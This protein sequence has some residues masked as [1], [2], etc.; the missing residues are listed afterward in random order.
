[1]VIKYVGWTASNSDYVC[2]GSNDQVPINEALA[3]AAANPGNTIYLRGPY[4]YDIYQTNVKIGSYTEL[5]GDSTAVLRLNNS[6]MWTAMVPVIGQI[7]GTG[8]VTKSV[9]IHGFQIDCNESHL[10]HAGVGSPERIRG[11][12]YYNAIYIVGQ[13]AKPAE[14]IQVYDM[15]I[16]DSMGDGPRIGFAT[17]IKIHDCTMWNMQHCAVFCIDSD[18]IDIYNNDLQ[19]ITCSAV[20]LDNCR[21]WKVHDNEIKDWL[22]TSSAPVGGAHGVQ[23]GNQPAGYGHTRQTDNGEVYNNTINVGACGIQIEDYYKSSGTTARTVHIH[24]NK[25]SG[26]GWQ[27]TWAAYFSGIAIFSWGNG[28]TIEKNTIENCY[29]AGILGYG[30]IASGVKA[31]I[32]NNNI[33]GTVAAGSTGGYGIWDKVS[34]ALTIVADNNYLSSNVSKYSGVTPVSESSSLIE[35]AVPTNTTDD[36]EEDDPTNEDVPVDIPSSRF[37]QKDLDKNYYI[38]G[39]TGYINGK[40]FRWKEKSVDVA[41]SVGQ[42][43]CPGVVGWSITDFDLNG[44][45]LTLD[46]FSMSGIREVHEAIAAFTQ[47]GRVT[48]E[49]GGDYAE[50]QV[51]GTKGDYSSKVRLNSDI[52]KKYHPYSLLLL[53][54][55]PYF[56]SVI[57]RYR[58]RY[59]TKSQSFSAD[60]CFKGNLVQNSSFDEWTPVNSMTWTT[61]ASARDNEWRCI[62]YAP[63]LKQFCAV[64]RTGTNTRVMISD[65]ETWR[66]PTGLTNANRNNYW[67][68][69]L[70][71]AEWGMW[72]ATSITGT[73][74]RCMIS[75]DGDNWSKKITPLDNAWVALLWI[76]PDSEPIGM[77]VAGDL[78]FAGAYGEL[79]Y[80]PE[81]GKHKA[82]YTGRVLAFANTGNYRVMYSD[83]KCE[84]W[85]AIPSAVETNSWSSAAYSPELHRI[86]VVASS[87]ETGQQVMTSDDFGDTWTARTTPTPNQSWNSVVWADALSLFVAVSSDGTKQIMT[88]PN[89]AT[90]TL[91]DTPI[92]SSTVTAGSG[93]I[94]S[95]T[96]VSPDGHAYPSSAI[97]YEEVYTTSVP[98]LTNGNFYRID[99]VAARLKTAVAG[100][101][102][103]MK[104]TAETASLGEVTLATWSNN[105]TSYVQ[106]LKDVAVLTATN[107]ALTIHYYLETSV[108]TARAHST[109]LQCK[110]TETNGGGSVVDYTNE[111]TSLVWSPS[112]KVLVA[113]AQTGELN[114][115]MHSVDALNWI[116]DTTPNNNAWVSV[117]YAE[118]FNRF[119]A[120][121]ITGTGNRVMIS[122]DYGS[123]RVPDSWVSVSEGQSR[124]ESTMEDG[125]ALRIT[126][127][128]TTVDRGVTTQP[129][130]LSAGVRYLLSGYGKVEGLTS[131]SLIIDVYSGD[132]AIKGLEWVSDT[133]YLQKQHSFMFNVAP[134]NVSVRVR[135]NNLNGGAIVECDHV[136]VEKASDLEM[137]FVGTDVATYG[138]VD[139]YPDIILTGVTHAPDF[140]IPGETKSE[141]TPEDVEY[142]SSSTQYSSETNSLVYTFR[143]PALENEAYYR[144]DQVS[145][146]LKTAYAGRIAYARATIQT[147]G[148][149]S[150]SETTLV[151]WTHNTTT[152]A[153]KSKSLNVESLAGDDIYI[154]F[155]LKTSNPTYRAS[156]ISFKYVATEI[157]TEAGGLSTKDVKIHNAADPA[158]VM[159]CCDTLLPKYSLEI[160][161]NGTGNLSYSE[162]FEDDNY[163]DTA[164]ASSGVTY[165][166]TNK[167]IVIGSGGYITFQ[168]PCKFPVTGIPYINLYALAGSPQIYIAEDVSG[169]PG[170]FYEV[171]GNL[172]ADVENEVVAKYLNCTSL[173]LKTK[174][175]YYVKITPRGSGTCEFGSLYEYAALSTVDAERFKL[176]A[177]I[178]ANTIAVSVDGKASCIATLKYHDLDPAV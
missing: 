137:L 21:K 67:W 121:S 168:F 154:R 142:V 36:E 4:T 51:T 52:P 25:I 39:R 100:K 114:G 62:Q 175:K 109:G 123:F 26:C 84:T 43:K 65:G 45:E 124:A 94:S 50:W 10:T 57:E 149:Y 116:S 92:K 115:C 74:D 136:L 30:A 128:G 129:L 167:S 72:I 98:A 11:K 99:K 118:D 90:W 63:E 153:E 93:D 85:K 108:A 144:L 19:P 95:V 87:G 125:Y 172:S 89:G 59:I 23:F 155:Y 32:K 68:A 55:Q 41:N 151:E 18:E 163:L 133:G 112:L 159:E 156:A 119:A 69:L 73:E 33:T 176:L 150:G 53:M 147:D 126:G 60:N 76:P 44:A 75:L 132:T 174:V 152:Y 56:E 46:C 9:K 104:V 2:D 101:V 79:F 34:S 48:I 77:K 113:V 82:Q 139:V 158:T 37:Y 138:T 38:E 91:V 40:P 97:S 47:P 28:L 102:A 1:M 24:H 42:D 140:A 145:C 16:H 131:G 7:G 117:C 164:Y 130:S 6:C 80:M 13:L 148:R 15:E 134:S 66:Y 49:L 177:G 105:T 22:G 173:Q 29:R 165:N 143:L 170:T 88:S 54:D 135:G 27:Y 64:S 31:T 107:E 86:V 169:T 14:D 127:D 162:D 157:T 96:Y 78:I 83:D 161:A 166:E 111:W 122:E 61:Q 17:G 171:S 81:A 160:N 3:W 20:R 141:I 8:T 110:I 103:S 58:S 71:A 70:W 120:V 5:T 146:K 35:G 12:G 106:K 178:G